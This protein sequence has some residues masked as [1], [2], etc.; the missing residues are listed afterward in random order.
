MR[1]HSEG[2][3]TCQLRSASGPSLRSVFSRENRIC[4]RAY[5]VH[6]HARSVQVRHGCTNTRVRL[7]RPWGV[8]T[9]Q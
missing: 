5:G 4:V 2:M 8:G 7:L 9:A 3:A 6:L 1:S